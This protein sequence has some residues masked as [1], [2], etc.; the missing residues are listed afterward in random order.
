MAGVQPSVGEER[1]EVED[2]ELDPQACCPEQADE[3]VESAGQPPAL[4]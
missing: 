4:G 2:E 1:A 3:E